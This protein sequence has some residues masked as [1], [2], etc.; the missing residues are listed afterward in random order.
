MLLTYSIN[1]KEE[2]ARKLT[3][4]HRVWVMSVE[5]FEYLN[6]CP[7]ILLSLTCKAQVLSPFQPLIRTLLP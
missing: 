2:T 6:L 5:K 1:I 4:Y 7:F 3:I